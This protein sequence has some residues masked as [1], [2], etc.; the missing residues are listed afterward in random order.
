MEAM[1][2]KGNQE[3]M[4]SDEVSLES[5]AAVLSKSAQALGL[6]LE[7]LAES[8][9]RKNLV[10]KTAPSVQVPEGEF[11]HRYCVRGKNNYAIFA[12]RAGNVETLQILE[13]KQGIDWRRVLCDPGELKK[14]TMSTDGELTLSY[15]HKGGDRCIVFTKGC[16]DGLLRAAYD[17]VGAH[18]KR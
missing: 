14:R 6:T 13:V 3:I 8:A 10:L 2:G 11:Y 9:D 4:Y 1:P 5:I 16:I 17:A 15:S 18:V 7:L 12:K